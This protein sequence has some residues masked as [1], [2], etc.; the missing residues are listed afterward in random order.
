MVDGQYQAWILLQ[1]N[2]E[3]EIVIP[4]NLTIDTYM[5][6]IST[7]NKEFF[8]IYPNPFRDKTSISF[9]LSGQ[10]DA[11]MDIFNLQGV[12]VR[13]LEF[14]PGNQHDVRYEWDGCDNNGNLLPAGIYLL[15]VNTGV[16]IEFSR[17]VVVR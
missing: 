16:T 4:V 1:D 15:K 8:D 6:G 13:T 17:I 3:S 11:R 12:V 2:F 10:A 5:G 9:S 7:S 14:A